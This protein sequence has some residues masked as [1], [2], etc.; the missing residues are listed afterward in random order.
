MAVA[1]S[2][3]LHFFSYEQFL[4]PVVED[5][6]DELP[7]QFTGA[8]V[9]VPLRWK[10]LGALPL[11]NVITGVVVSGLST[12]RHAQLHDLGLGRGGRRARGVHD[13][14]RADGP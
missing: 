7:E 3:I 4:R 11:I 9:G 10:L 1:Y 2:A 6:V 14:A 5:I 13:L 12:E 8:P